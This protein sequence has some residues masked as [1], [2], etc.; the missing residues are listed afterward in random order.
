MGSSVVATW[1]AYR[2]AGVLIHRHPP[3]GSRKKKSALPHLYKVQTKNAGI[4]E[5]RMFCSDDFKTEINNFNSE[6]Y[7]V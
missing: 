2:M 1:V 4:F 6:I 5:S 7:I 3:D